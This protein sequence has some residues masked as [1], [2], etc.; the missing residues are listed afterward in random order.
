MVPTS[1]KPPGGFP[2]YYTPTPPERVF[3]ELVERIHRPKHPNGR[4]LY[5]LRSVVPTTCDV[6]DPNFLANSLWIIP[7]NAT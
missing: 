1:K 2:D 5:G 7:D 3:Q 6:S 4:M